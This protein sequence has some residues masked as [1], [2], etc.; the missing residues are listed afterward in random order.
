MYGITETTVHV[1]YRPIT[2][3]DLD[4]GGSMIGRAIP[5]LQVY[6]LD[7]DLRSVPE[8]VRFTSV[9]PDSRAAT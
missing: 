9:G 7:D 8:M 5:D 6:V 3:D 2:R 1:T 4:A